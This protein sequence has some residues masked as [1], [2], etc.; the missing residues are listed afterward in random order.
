MAL[1]SLG[2]KLNQAEIQQL[3]RQLAAAGYRVVDGAA[4]A[5]IYILNTCTVTH[6]ADRK[7]RHL[8]RLARKRHPAARLV[9]IGCYAHRAPAELA[10]IQ[11]VELVLGNDRKMELLGLL[12]DDAAAEH[13]VSPAASPRET[14]RNRAFLKIQ[15]GCRNFCAYCIVPLVRSK[16]ENVPAE[17]VAGQV[18]EL[19]AQG[20]KEVVLTGTE[21]GAYHSR[22]VNLE[23]LIK[24]ILAET[25]VTRLRLSSLQPHQATPSLIG[26]WRDARLCPHFHLSLQS[27]S[28]TVLK[29]MNRKYTAADF[30]KTVTLIR[31]SV[32]DA[33][34]TTDIIA[35]FP[36]ETDAEFKET[37]D[38]CRRA[39][40]ARMHVFPF[41]ARPG[42]AAATMPSQITAEIKKERAD[43]MLALARESARAFQQLFLG[44]T[45]EVLW[46]QGR[47][48][49][50]S[51]LTGN[52]IKVYI[53]SRNDLADK[54]QSVKLQKLYRDGV[55]GELP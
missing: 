23:G 38:F 33:A 50:W 29:R 40:F 10:Q 48:G 34:I 36:G 30:L 55:W 6:V 31:E 45:L 47:G 51:G 14:G 46:E 28:D 52:Y 19:A 15:S 11:G 39:K 20:C 49:I 9:A 5:D 4:K 8:L 35:G 41:S 44:R 21:I 16:E 25:T 2:C 54:I 7:S 3:A 26:L 32:P 18:K 27:G 43:A 17:K 24:R 22:G 13:R 12:G 42:T 37:L 1:D 53:R